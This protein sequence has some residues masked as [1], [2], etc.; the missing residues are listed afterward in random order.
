[1]LDVQRSQLWIADLA[2]DA[3]T[4]IVLID[5]AEWMLHHEIRRRVQAL[6]V[7][8]F[9][10]QQGQYRDRINE[11][12]ADYQIVDRVRLRGRLDDVQVVALTITDPAIVAVV[13]LR[14]AAKLELT[15]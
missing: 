1:M 11:A 13:E 9:A 7:F 2:Y 3:S 12:I 14:G 10:E 15:P 5:V 4:N 6:L 8:S